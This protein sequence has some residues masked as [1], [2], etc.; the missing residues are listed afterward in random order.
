M[1]RLP[2]SYEDVCAELDMVTV[3]PGVP[4]AGGGGGGCR[5]RGA[6]GAAQGLTPALHAFPPPGASRPGGS[7]L[8]LLASD[9]HPAVTPGP[10]GPEPGYF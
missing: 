5:F 6:D 3:A 9:I 1:W 10:G 2:F 7:A 8:L 4:V